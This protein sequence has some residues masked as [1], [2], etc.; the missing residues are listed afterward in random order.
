MSF[1]VGV[2]FSCTVSVWGSE[3]PHKHVILSG[4]H[5]AMCKTAVEQLGNSL[6][7]SIYLATCYALVIIVPFTDLLAARRG[8][9]IK[10]FFNI[11]NELQE[12]RRPDKS[13]I[14]PKK[15]RK[16][17]AQVKKII[18]DREKEEKDS[19]K[20]MEEVCSTVKN[21]KV[22]YDCHKHFQSK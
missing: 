11:K 6:F 7:L 3:K 19:L 1:V 8:P 17:F 13:I 12:P 5:H 4:M 22:H 10:Y 21:E 14:K 9:I 2:V 16:T 20:D 18:A 15:Q